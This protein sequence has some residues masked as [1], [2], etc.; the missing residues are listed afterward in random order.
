MV[1]IYLHYI[2]LGIESDVVSTTSGSVLYWSDEWKVWGGC[3]KSSSVYFNICLSKGVYV[4]ALQD[5][6]V[7]VI[8]LFCWL[9]NHFGFRERMKSKKM[10]GLHKNISSHCLTD[11]VLK[12]LNKHL[13]F[14]IQEPTRILLSFHISIQSICVQI[15]CTA[16][17]INVGWW[18]NPL[19]NQLNFPCMYVYRKIHNHVWHSRVER[20]FTPQS[21]C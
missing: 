17:T 15:F 14:C 13:T 1:C 12:L 16:L 21:P 11:Q 3:K 20:A 2:T 4:G 8:D 10:L 5:G 18:W 6:I 9:L 19:K 7:Y